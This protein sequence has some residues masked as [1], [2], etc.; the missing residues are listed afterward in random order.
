MGVFDMEISII[1]SKKL[2]NIVELL[3]HSRHLVEYDEIQLTISFLL[4]Y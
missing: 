2:L 3:L 4:P 1:R